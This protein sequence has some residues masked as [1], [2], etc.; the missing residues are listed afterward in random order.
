MCNR[1]VSPEQAEIER[2]RHIGQHNQPTWW[3][4][5]EVYPRGLGP[6]IRSERDSDGR[7]EN[8][9]LIGMWGLIPWFAKSPKRSYS[10]N[11]ARAE[12]VATKASFKQS[13]N[14]GRRCIIPAW[15]YDEPC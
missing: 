10:T 13:W 6:F 5:A 8:S 4:L 14:D 3:K 1:Y 7:L 15:S 2:F 11:N 9:L 12:E